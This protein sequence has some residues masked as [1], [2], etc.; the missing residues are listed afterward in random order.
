[1]QLNGKILLFYYKKLQFS[2]PPEEEA[3]ASSFFFVPI[4]KG[5][6]GIVYV[7]FVLGMRLVELRYTFWTLSKSMQYR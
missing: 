2:A 6:W 7:I 3:R 5:L 1:M 4:Y